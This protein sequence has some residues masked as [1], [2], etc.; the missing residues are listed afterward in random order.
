MLKQRLGSMATLKAGVKNG[1]VLTSF[2]VTVSSSVTESNGRGSTDAV[3]IIAT[4][5]E[6]GYIKPMIAA[7]NGIQSGS[8]LYTSSRSISGNVA[9]D[10]RLDLEG[11]Q[12]SDIPLLANSNLG[13]KQSA[14]SAGG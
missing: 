2:P 4:P 14:H 12:F 5:A 3:Y 7:R 8:M 9:L 10:N 1:I 6:M 13:L 11:L